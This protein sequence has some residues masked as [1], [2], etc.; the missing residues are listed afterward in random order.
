MKK[1]VCFILALIMCL[2][3]CACS[4]DASNH[5][6]SESS[7]SETKKIIPDLFDT[8]QQ[9]D[10]PDIVGAWKFVNGDDFAPDIIIFYDD[11]TYFIINEHNAEVRSYWKNNYEIID[12]DELLMYDYDYN[13]EECSFT[14]SYE[15][16][17]NTMT[18]YES[19]YERIEADRYAGSVLVGTWQGYGGSVFCLPTE[20]R[21]WTSGHNI[22]FYND[23]SYNIIYY[24][25][26]DWGDYTDKTYGSYNII[27]DGEALYILQDRKEKIIEFEYLGYGL[28]LIEPPFNQ[29]YWYS[30]LE[31]TK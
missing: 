14:V 7:V 17:E 30:L 11:N 4:K 16:E 19:V 2:S 3:L 28:M 20:D 24:R 9:K 25:K 6:P 13:G 23:G 31:Y 12:K 22:T 18:Y 26:T 29:S 10:T 8:K 21:G 15:I 5:E 1:I 27:N